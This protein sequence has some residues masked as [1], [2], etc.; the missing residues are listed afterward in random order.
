MVR[1]QQPLLHL[2]ICSS[3]TSSSTGLILAALSLTTPSTIAEKSNSSF[4]ASS[5]NY[6]RCHATSSAHAKPTPGPFQPTYRTTSTVA[7]WQHLPRRRRGELSFSY[8][9]AA[10]RRQ[11][12]QRNMV[13]CT[14]KQRRVLG[15]GEQISSS[16]LSFL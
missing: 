4:L 16:F 6:C 7:P 2:T 15:E 1:G 13:L 12:N 9:S 5:P 14:G 11:R 3:D 8:I 10:R